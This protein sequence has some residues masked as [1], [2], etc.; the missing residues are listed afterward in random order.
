[1]QVL[2]VSGYIDEPTA[3]A[4]RLLPEANRA[5]NSEGRMTC[6]EP[7]CTNDPQMPVIPCILPACSLRSLSIY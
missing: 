6:L 3:M 7:A 5:E 1:M 2:D 4:A